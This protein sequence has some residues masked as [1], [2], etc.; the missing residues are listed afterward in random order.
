ELVACWREANKD[1]AAGRFIREFIKLELKPEQVAGDAADKE[2]CDLLQKSGW[3]IG[4]Q[5]FG[6]PSVAKMVYQ[7]WG[8]QAWQEGAAGIARC[9]WIIPQDDTLGAELT[10]RKK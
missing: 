9:E 7:S 4:R 6:A 8:A 2:M 3:N 1:A 5:N 10:T